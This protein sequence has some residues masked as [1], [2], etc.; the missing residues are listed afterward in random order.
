MAW[1]LPSLT[2]GEPPEAPALE[3]RHHYGNKEGKAYG[4]SAWTAIAGKTVSPRP[5]WALGTGAKGLPGPDTRGSRERRQQQTPNEWASLQAASVKAQNS[6][7]TQKHA[8][9]PFC[10]L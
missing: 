10:P 1:K 3:L 5:S 7:L 9:R 6:D 8:L 2:A 4:V